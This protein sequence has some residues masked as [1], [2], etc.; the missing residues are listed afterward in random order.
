MAKNQSIVN[1]DRDSISFGQR[2]HLARKKGGFSLRKLSESTGGVI[3]HEMIR[4]LENGSRV[5]EEETL[6]KLCQALGV[7]RDYLISARRITLGEVEFRKKAKTTSAD[8]AAIRTELLELLERYL[9]IEQLL[10]LD[11]LWQL[12]SLVTRGEDKDVYAESMAIAL[13]KHW[14]LGLEPIHDFTKLLEEKGLKVF[15]PETSLDISGLTCEVQRSD[16]DPLFAIVVNR[17]H[18]LERRRFSMAH[19]LGHRVLDCEGLTPKES[20]HLCNR[21]AAAF[22]VP[23]ETLQREMGKRQRP[24]AYREI[25]LTKKFFRVSAA[26]L[27]MRLEQIGIMDLMQRDW[28]FQTV[29]Q[30]WRKVE[31]EPLESPGPTSKTELPRFERLVYQA[32]ASDFISAEKAAE[33]LR[34]PLRE[35][36]RGLSGGYGID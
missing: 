29:A 23:K 9:E 26:M 36:E 16:G 13:R 24:V 27:V 34:A 5:P 31:P 3:S 35:V 14:K 17:E 22:L 4:Q 32:L 28:F 10:E 20:E 30:G 21:F 15:I 12:P 19:E 2:L 8:R 6:A 1:E 11:E 7:S 25:I 33:L 18:S